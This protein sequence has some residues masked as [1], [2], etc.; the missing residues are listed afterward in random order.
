M[1]VLNHWERKNINNT[2]TL[3]FAKVDGN[4]S[5]RG[6]GYYPWRAPNGSTLFY[7][8]DKR[9]NA[10]IITLTSCA[11]LGPLE[12]PPP[13]TDL[14][15]QE[16]SSKISILMAVANTF[17]QN[18]QL[19]SISWCILIYAV[20]FRKMNLTYFCYLCSECRSFFL[21]S[22]RVLTM[23]WKFPPPETCSS[24][25]SYTFQESSHSRCWPLLT[26]KIESQR[27]DIVGSSDRWRND[28]LPLVAYHG[29]H[30]LAI[31]HQPK[32]ELVNPDSFTFSSR[33]QPQ[34]SYIT[35][36][37][38]ALRDFLKN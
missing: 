18:R 22:H 9:F 12:F 34:S 35:N 25:N 4:D 36:T 38:S 31:L 3:I 24:A 37:D 2:E 16:M 11:H 23:S 20:H 6:T 10:M 33:G 7:R 26:A 15:T 28:V 17:R 14:A 1:W 27:W 8:N 5:I 21:H 30:I 29:Y 32:N 13:G 19:T